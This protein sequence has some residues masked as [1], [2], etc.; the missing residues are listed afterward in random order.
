LASRLVSRASVGQHKPEKQ[1][2]TNN[3]DCRNNGCPIWLFA[4]GASAIAIRVAHTKTPS[5]HKINLFILEQGTLP[6]QGHFLLYLIGW[7]L[8]A[9]L[10]T[11]QTTPCCQKKAE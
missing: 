2:N 3:R 4:L 7:R 5:S 9:I 1:K 6:V 8:Y 11:T 10:P